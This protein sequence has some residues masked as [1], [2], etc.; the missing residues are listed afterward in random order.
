MT[1]T[2]IVDKLKSDLAR[3]EALIV[4]LISEYKDEIRG[5]NTEI[6]ELTIKLDD[7]K[8]AAQI[9][10]KN[11]LSLQDATGEGCHLDALEWIK[12]KRSE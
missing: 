4:Q 7:Q 9:Y 11:W 6:D 12:G 1:R 10:R 3:L 5:K 8:D 2:E